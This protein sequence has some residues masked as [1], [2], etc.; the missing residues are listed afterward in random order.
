MPSLAVPLLREGC[1]ATAVDLEMLR[2]YIRLRGQIDTAPGCAPD[3]WRKLA[4]T[5]FEPQYLQKV[6][7]GTQ[8]AQRMAVTWVAA[9]GKRWRPLLTAT[10]YDALQP[11]NRQADTRIIAPIAIAAECFHKASL[12][13]DDIEDDDICR[14]GRPTLH[15]QYNLPLALNAGDLLLGEGYRLL[16]EA[17]LPADTRLRLLQTAAE[18][19]RRL[20]IGQGEELSWRNRPAPPDT[21]ELLDL[22]RLKTA[23]AFEVAILLGAIAGGG[24]P[25]ICGILADFSRAL[26]IAYQI[27]D[28]LSDINRDLPRSNEQRPS[29]LLAL[30]Q[31]HCGHATP[32]A[33]LRAQYDR[34]AIP[35]RAERMFMDYRNQS[36]QALNPITSIRLKSLLVRLV[37]RILPHVS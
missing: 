5:W 6:M 20:C 17:Q 23:S 33:N 29:I 16:A 15:A 25:Q 14:D 32:G 7:P 35:A 13:H 2:A 37:K 21:A 19:H 11:D 18:G 8:H 26:G 34:C 12:I 27:R 3:Q 28:D 10:V 36:L 31:E 1:N 30:L 22:F 4:Q 24:G 9:A